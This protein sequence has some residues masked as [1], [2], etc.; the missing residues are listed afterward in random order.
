MIYFWNPSGHKCISGICSNNTSIHYVTSHVCN[1]HLDLNTRLNGDRCNL[2]H[3]IRRRVQ[4]DQALMNPHLEAVPRVCAFSRTLPD[5]Q[6][7][8][9]CRE[10]H[11]TSNVKVLL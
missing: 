2:L 3:D 6:A 7:K 10:A 1:G 9:L 4:I 11:W 5:T 8:F